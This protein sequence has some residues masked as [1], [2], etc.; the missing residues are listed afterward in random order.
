M[1]TT[2]RAADRHSLDLVLFTL[3]GATAFLQ[4]LRSS[5]HDQN[6][7]VFGILRWSSIRSS[8][9][10]FCQRHPLEANVIFPKLNQNCI[11]EAKL[12]GGVPLERRK[13]SKAT[14]CLICA[15]QREFP[16]RCP[17]P[18]VLPS[19]ISSHSGQPS[20]QYCDQ[21]AKTWVPAGPRNYKK[22]QSYSERCESRPPE[23]G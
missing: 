1:L 8:L 17:G 6:S 16:Q 19:Q 12:Q 4:V 13:Q 20:G 18:D 10:E 5:K 7:L 14:S 3:A 9:M 2:S 22:E 15:S 11:R 21:P 23:R